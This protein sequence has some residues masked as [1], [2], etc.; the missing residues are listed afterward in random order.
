MKKYIFLFIITFAFSS[1]ATKGLYSWDK[2]QQ[3][4]YNYL[5]KADEKSIDQIMKQY[6]KIIKKQKGT[7]LVT[8][9]GMYAD[10]GFFLVQRGDLKNGRVN[11]N[12]EISLYPE[13]KVFID[14]ILKLIE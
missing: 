1:C 6:K 10:Y 3:A 7:R 12:K 11:L 2:Y 8:P 9:P 4:S 13:S 5:K 14:R